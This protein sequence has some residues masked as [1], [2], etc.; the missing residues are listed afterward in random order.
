MIQQQ[1]N[2]LAAYR[3]GFTDYLTQAAPDPDLVVP[4]YTRGWEDAVL[5]FAKPDSSP[6]KE[7]GEILEELQVERELGDDQEPPQG[8]TQTEDVVSRILE[9]FQRRLM[10]N[11]NEVLGAEMRLLLSQDQVL[12]LLTGFKEILRKVVDLVMRYGPKTE[13]IKFLGDYQDTVEQA[14]SEVREEKSLDAAERRARIEGS[15]TPAEERLT[16]NGEN[17][18][19]QESLARTLKRME[20]EPGEQ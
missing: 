16:E 9:V 3:K 5:L 20:S 6:E 11:R 8:W 12:E 10:T 14:L 7:V 2:E 17:L 13:D 4:L 15:T 18:D 19:V 1:E